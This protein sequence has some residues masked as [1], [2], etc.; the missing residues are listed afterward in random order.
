MY[1]TDYTSVILFS[2][3]SFITY[4][5]NKNMIIILLMA[6][7]IVN[8]LNLFIT[9]NNEGYTNELNDEDND[10]YIDIN[11][12]TDTSEMIKAISSIAFN[13]LMKDDISNNTINELEQPISET[14][15]KSIELQNK[16]DKVDNDSNITNSVI[17]NKINE[18]NNKMNELTSLIQ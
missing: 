12:E 4:I 3:V 13:K 1:N 15:N 8:S 14:K 5:F 9:K 6:I 10:N 17:Y 16:I 2:I 18:L 11:D 7:I